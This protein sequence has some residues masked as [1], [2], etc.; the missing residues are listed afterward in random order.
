[1]PISGLKAHRI[2]SW[3]L[4]LLALLTVLFGYISAR[5]LFP[6]YDLFIFLHLAMQ[7]SLI[8][9]TILHLILSRKYMK[10]KMSRIIKGLKSEKAYYTSLLR[11]VQ[12]ITKWAIII[13]AIL[14]GI[15]GMLYFEWYALLFGDFFIF[16][17]HIDYNLLLLL[18]LIVHIGIGAKFYLTRKRINHWS[19]NLL[20]LVVSSSLMIIVGV[21][22]WPPGQQAFDVRI[23]DNIYKFNP[24]VDDIQINSSRPD[25]FQSG[26]FS[27]FDVLLYL[28]STGEVDITYHFDASMDT[29]VID[30][31]NGEVNW[32]YYAYYSG[33]SLEHNVVRMDFY[34]WK[35]GT[36][37]LVTQVEQSHIDHIYSTFQEEVSNLAVNNGTVIVPVVT[38]TGRTFSQEFYN[39]TVSAH[40]LRNDTFQNGIITALDIIMSL[41]DLGDITYELNWYESFRGSFYVHSYFVEKINADETIGRCGFLYEV[42][43]NDFKTPGPNYI[44][45]ASDE[46]VLISPEYLRFFWD[47]L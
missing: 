37:L 1:M 30:M 47:C 3:L 13:L 46:R 11:L 7:W 21:V 35:P 27:L 2:T 33:G 34:P 4:V 20:I 12:R 42:G 24:E 38:I 44:F 10:L 17:W 16:D 9:I 5:R 8:S 31:L 41:G 25:I 40:N 43:D 36:T 39:I 26:S 18:F 45:L 32:W 6:P 28:N 22:N 15:S 23:G 19:L 14:I 29:Y